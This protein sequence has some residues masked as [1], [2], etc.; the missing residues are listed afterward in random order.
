MSTPLPD[1]LFSDF[2]HLELNQVFFSPVLC[3]K[4]ADFLQFYF[5]GM[6]PKQDGGIDRTVVIAHVDKL[7]GKHALLLQART[8][9]RQ[10]SIR[11]YCF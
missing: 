8:G 3:L 6:L 9:G 10:K 7:G 4:I 1:F 5:A 11:F 2:I